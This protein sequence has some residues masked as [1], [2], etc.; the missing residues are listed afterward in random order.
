MLKNFRPLT[1]ERAQ[2]II[3]NRIGLKN[4]KVVERHLRLL[5]L[6]GVIKRAHDI[7][8]FTGVGL[9]FGV[10]LKDVDLSDE[11]LSI[12]EKN[13]YFERLFNPENA[14]HIQLCIFIKALAAN[15]ISKKSLVIDY[16]QKMKPFNI[17]KASV[18]ER[19][20]DL[21]KRT[22]NVSSFLNNRVRCQQKWIEALGLS[23]YGS[24][25]LNESG[26]RMAHEIEK[27][28]GMKLCKQPEIYKLLSS[29]DI[30]LAP[31]SLEKDEVELTSLFVEASKTIGTERRA[32]TDFVKSYMFYKLLNTH[33]YFDDASFHGLL[34]LLHGKKIIESVMRGRDGEIHS[35][36]LR[37]SAL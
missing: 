31:I 11:K 8:V 4:K 1:P 24:L 9:V 2:W 25:M 16:F 12:I 15:P 3:E 27:Y 33:R 6:L 20:I 30:L 26:E 23:E 13:F 29:L 37:P 34:E 10:F 35:V 7:F 18:V 19:N 32:R 22:G 5:E 36:T 17:W 21:L 28:P 14:T